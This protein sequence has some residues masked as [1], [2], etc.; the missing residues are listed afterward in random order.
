MKQATTYLSSGERELLRSTLQ[1]LRK[2]STTFVEG[3][4]VAPAD[5]EMVI[6]CIHACGYFFVKRG[7]VKQFDS[8]CKKV[9]DLFMKG[10][11]G[12]DIELK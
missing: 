10:L 7:T 9:H 6:Q 2:K 1:A 11:I 12:K 8:Y 3:C 4:A 5:I